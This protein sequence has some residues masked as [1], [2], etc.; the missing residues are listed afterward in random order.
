MSTIARSRRAAT[1]S[2]KTRGKR[3]DGAKDFRRVLDRKDI[4]ICLIG[5]PDHWHALQTILA[6]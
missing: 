5:T 3:P 2:K 1:S 6:C 4:D